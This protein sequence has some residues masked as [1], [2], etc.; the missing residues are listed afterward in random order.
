M[1]TLPWVAARTPTVHKEPVRG[2]AVGGPQPVP[3]DDLRQNDRQ[4]T[5]SLESDVRYNNQVLTDTWNLTWQRSSATI[6]WQTSRRGVP[7][8]QEDRAEKRN[9]SPRRRSTRR[10][11][12][13][14][15]TRPSTSRL[16]QNQHTDKIVDVCCNAA[17][18]FSDSNDPQKSR[19]RKPDKWIWAEPPTQ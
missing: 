3:R 8:H 17:K 19:T 18:S 5:T 15:R 10:P 13:P 11:N 6:T 2:K 9:T 7:D 12:T 16:P 1:T 14:L 4:T